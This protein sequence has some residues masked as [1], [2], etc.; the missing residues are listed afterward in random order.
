LELR[1]SLGDRPIFV[2]L[3]QALHKEL[4]LH[5]FL[6]LIFLNLVAD[7]FDGNKCVHSLPQFALTLRGLCDIVID[8]DEVVVMRL[9]LA[10]C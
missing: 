7:K 10:V 9:D 1:E 4:I 3:S 6:S 8:E 5:I 2:A